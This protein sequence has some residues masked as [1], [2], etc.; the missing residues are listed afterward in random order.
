MDNETLDPYIV[1]EAIM[2]IRRRKGISQEEVSQAVDI[3]RSHLSA[4]ECGRRKPTLETFYR[5][6]CA[7]D[8]NMSEIVKEIEYKIDRN[9]KYKKQA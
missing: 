4:I 1:G 3:G 5:I 6:A 7:M 8:V 9:V 2:E